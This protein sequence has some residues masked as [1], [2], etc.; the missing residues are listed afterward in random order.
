MVPL[1]YN[2]TKKNHKSIT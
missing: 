1:L 2:A